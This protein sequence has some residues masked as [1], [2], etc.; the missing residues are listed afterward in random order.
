VACHEQGHALGMGH[1]L[2]TSGSCLYGTAS[3]AAGLLVPSGQDFALIAN[4]Y[5]T[6]H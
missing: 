5:S 6:R 4:L 3:N 2:A 1:N